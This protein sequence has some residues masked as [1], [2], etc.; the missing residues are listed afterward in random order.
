MSSLRFD[1]DQGRESLAQFRNVNESIRAE[2][3]TVQSTVDA[4]IGGAWE[5]PAAHQFDSSIVQWNQ[6]TNS[7]TNV[8]DNLNH[9]LDVAIQRWEEMASRLGGG[10]LGGL[11]GGIGDLFSGAFDF[12]GDFMSSGIGQFAMNMLPI[13]FPGIGG[14]ATGIFGFVNGIASGEGFMDSIIGGGLDFLGS[15]IPDGSGIV[16][17]ITDAVGVVSDVMS[18]DYAG[19]IDT[20]AGLLGGGD[21]FISGIAD[22]V[23]DA[24]G[25][26]GGL[27]AI[28]N[29]SGIAG[30]ISGIAGDIGGIADAIGNIDDIGDVADVIGDIGGISDFF[31]L[32]SVSDTMNDVVGI[33]DTA[34]DIIGD[35]GN[36][37]GGV[38]D[39]VSSWW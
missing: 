33:V 1:T 6:I 4:L 2:I 8:L 12:V 19:L 3:Q 18:S 28:G 16:G 37:G 35:I 30:D 17:T 21:N 14:I 38:W 5:A 34:G 31:G 29:I 23:S 39:A 27:G 7:T 24:I 32:D 36:I 26:F 9:R 22:T 13:A 15:V 10:F 25:G 20:A 11:I